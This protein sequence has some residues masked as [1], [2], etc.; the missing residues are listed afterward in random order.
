MTKLT[1]YIAR[2]G[3][4]MMNT[5]RRVQGWCDSPLTSAGIE[6]ARYLGYGFDQ[7]GINF[8]SV[9]C[10]DL[11]RTR[12][13]AQIVLASKG[14]DDIPITEC[15]GLREACFG[16]YE[17]GLDDDMWLHAALHLQYTSSEEMTQSIIKKEITYGQVLDAIKRLDK[18]D[19]AESFAEV[20]A[21]TLESLLEIAKKES[22][23]GDGNIFIVSHGM[24]ILCMLHNLGGDKLLTKVLDNASVCKVVYSDEKFTIQS[25]GDMSYVELGKN[26]KV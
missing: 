2:H 3:K 9:Y 10:S 18:M 15:A 19:M 23:E 17:C 7:A 14:Q 21:R 5:L 11:R 6:V 26:Y 13:T 8:R 20:E 1:F 22:L 16:S 24:S 4:T 12:Q 25:M